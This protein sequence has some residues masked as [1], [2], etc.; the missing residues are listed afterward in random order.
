MVLV[1]VNL[2]YLKRL[3]YIKSLKLWNEFIF[4]TIIVPLG[5]QE[6]EA[7]D[8]EHKELN[9]NEKKVNDEQMRNKKIICKYHNKGC[10]I[11]IGSM[12]VQFSCKMERLSLKEPEHFANSTRKDVM[13]DICVLI[14]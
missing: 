11:F 8:A 3:N 2:E 10:C 4:L 7:L 6:I 1:D 14:I 9:Q 13:D 12:F 5:K